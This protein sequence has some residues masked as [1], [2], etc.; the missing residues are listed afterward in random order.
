MWTHHHTMACSKMLVYSISVTKGTGKVSKELG[1]I[2]VINNHIN[3]D[4]VFY[5]YHWKNTEIK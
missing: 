4:N 3:D 2:K 5:L 1:E